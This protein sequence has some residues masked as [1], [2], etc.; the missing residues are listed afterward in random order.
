MLPYIF[1]FLIDHVKISKCCNRIMAV[2]SQFSV[3]THPTCSE[4]IPTYVPLHTGVDIEFCV[5]VYPADICQEKLGGQGS[6]EVNL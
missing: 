1:I 6:E 2:D 5:L 3:Y 4:I